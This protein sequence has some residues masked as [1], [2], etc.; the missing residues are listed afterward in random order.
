MKLS[1]IIPTFNR[2]ETLKTT[3]LSLDSQ[4]YKDF[5]VIVAD[6]GSTDGTEDL[7]KKLKVS[8]PIRHCRQE[9]AG[10]SAAR[11]MG[12]ENASGELILFIDDHIVVDNKLVEEHVIC[13]TRY[14]KDNVKVVRGRVEFIERAEDAPKTTAYIDEAR[15][16]PPPWE[17][18]PFRIFITNNISVEK[19]AL[20]SVFGFDEDFKEYG[21]QDAE[22]GYR[23]KAAGYRFKVNPN[24]VGYIFGVGWTYEERCR[25]RRQ[26]GRS[27][28]L[29]YKKHP[30][31]LVKF[32]LSVH[33]ITILIQK[34]LSLFENKLPCLPAGMAKRML[35]FYNFTTGIKEG[36]E[37][38]KDKHY[39]KM[40][41]RFKADKKSI[42][43]VSH[44][45]DLSGAPISLSLLA[46][47]ISKEK[48][49]P[50]I[51]LPGPGPITAKL[52][53]AGVSYQIF[54]DSLIYKIF[55]S[56][57][58]YQ[59][60]KDR[61]VDLVYL[62]TSA[63]IWAAKAAK[64]LKIPVISHIREDLRGTNN[65][66]IRSKI[67]LCSDRIILISNWMKSFIRS[68][69]A[70]VVH[71]TVD[72]DDFKKLDPN[73]IRK[74]FN[75]RGP[76]LVFVGTLEERKGIRYLIQALPKIKTSYPHLKLLIVGST[77]PGQSNYLKNLKAL[78]RDP[79]LIFTGARVDA[80]DIM[81]ACDIVIAPSLS[82]PFGRVVI[83]AMACGKPVIASNV[84]GI[85]EIIE[86]EKT[87]M[88][89]NPKSLAD[90]AKEA[91]LLLRNN[92]KAKAMGIAGRKRVEQFFTIEKQIKEI[93][94][95]IDELF[96]K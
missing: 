34:V 89:I 33:F 47:N 88:L 17:Q 62:N 85:P 81:A 13:H 52:D 56:L 3:L 87:G 41:S 82:E 63:S 49:H 37:K 24:A 14:A 70:K 72:L 12:L 6:D 55:P 61:Q 54:K 21:L 32:N 36:L 60:I 59:M 2:K 9:N 80:Y 51:A 58:L 46:K 28:V 7:I 4:T 78:A 22:M 48:Y 20:L 10:R 27:S 40:H 16:K 92:E 25:R 18:Q 95:I 23:L 73:R 96:I 1:I 65:A 44:I 71:N 76:S 26:V 15:I 53:A 84:G 19:K 43:F 57:K 86:D 67:E 8:Y 66:L 94:A 74:E 45:S 38:Y 29:F 50:I 93:E 64:L 79:N 42:L 69:K 91:T 11:N 39:S 30:T 75:I 83:E 77:L 35:M 90:I 31:L 5:E 68:P